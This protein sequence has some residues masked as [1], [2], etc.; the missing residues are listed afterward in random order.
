M[1][2]KVHIGELPSGD[3]SIDEAR[4]KFSNNIS[5]HE[6]TTWQT[7]LDKLVNQPGLFRDLVVS[8]PGLQL[9]AI[10]DVLD[11]TVAFNQ[12]TVHLLN[13]KVHFVCIS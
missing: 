4:E 1:C 6:N 3:R 9:Q 7:N 2:S 10:N 8:S 11:G 13:L 5:S 12:F